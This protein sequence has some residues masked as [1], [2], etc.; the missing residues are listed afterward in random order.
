[1]FT[2]DCNLCLGNFPKEV[3]Y[4]RDMHKYA[5]MRTEQPKQKMYGSILKKEFL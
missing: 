2:S 5:A 4:S 1:M 3:I